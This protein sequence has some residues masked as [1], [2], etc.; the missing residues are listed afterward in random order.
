[1]SNKVQYDNKIGIDLDQVI[2]WKFFPSTENDPSP[3]LKLFIPG[4]SFTIRQRTYKRQ[5]L[6][7]SIIV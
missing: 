1:M 2:A 6:L 4:E 3:T 5:T 7:T